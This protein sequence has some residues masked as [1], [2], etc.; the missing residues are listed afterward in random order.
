MR[1][2]VI[3]PI[4]RGEN[5]LTDCLNSLKEGSFR[6]MEVLVVGDHVEEFNPEEVVKPYAAELS[7]RVLELTDQTGTAAARNLGLA[8]A[9][10]DY[11]FFL[12][13]D[14][15]IY[16]DLLGRLSA[17]A[18]EK[19]ADIAY[20][21]IVPTWVRHDVFQSTFDPE[22]IKAPRRDSETGGL[23]RHEL[24]NVA[25]QQ[26]PK[27]VT[28]SEDLLEARNRLYLNTNGIK[29]ISV[30]GILMRRAV[31]EKT[32]IRFNSEFTY[33]SDLSFVSELLSAI[34]S[35]VYCD[36]AIYVKR[37][38]NDPDFFPSLSQIKDENKFDEYIL[39]YYYTC[40][41]IAKTGD[42]RAC[43]D[44]K[45]INYYCGFFMTRLH[46]SGNEDWKGLRFM[47]MCEI[48]KQLHPAAVESL[49]WYQ[50]HAVA[51]LKAGNANASLKLVNCRL[52]L[53]KLR[54][55]CTKHV[56]ISKFC[57]RHFFLKKPLLENTVLCETFFGKSYSDSPK[58]IYEYLQKNYPG[59]YRFVW[60]VNQKT[61]IP[62]PHKT[63][64]RFSVRYAYY[65]ARAK[66]FV[67]NV[68]QP[69]WAQKREGNIF[70]ETWHGTPL[71]KLVFD[72]EEVMAAS[73]L[74]K[75]QFFKQVQHWDYLVAANQFSSETFRSC[76]KFEKK[77]LEYGYPRNDILHSPDREE[78]AEK[79]RAKLGIPKDKK[80]ILYAPTWRDDEY[81][82]RGEYKFALKF[83]LPKMREALGP[84]YVLLLRTH[85]FIADSIDTTGVEDFAINVSHYDDISELY[86]ISDILITDYSSVFFDYAGLRR[87]ILF[88]PY[89][90][91]KYRD[92]LRGFYIS[93][94]DDVPGPLL[95]TQDEIVQGIRNIDQIEAQY[96]EKY[97]IFYERFCK[98]E[99][100]HAAEN[101]AKE[102][103]GLK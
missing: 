65:L 58:Y 72:Q 96:Q 40:G 10:G 101:C 102:V 103:F 87:P 11:V 22:N 75:H 34:R 35:A 49:R 84:D 52:A 38:H 1:V 90:L 54:D 92:V 85:Y 97:D 48:A 27:G 8:E 4:N 3:I 39:A 63:V 2:S 56:E 32:K 26:P 28:L 61:K 73:P 79:I 16:G 29:S 7:A 88:Y 91:E 78:I 14:D 6:D 45:L 89:D 80:T 24:D 50:S 68:R 99:D 18:E 69:T 94:E 62:Y 59:R 82:G 51:L 83:D 19:N 93:I 60:V 44:R 21:K 33:Y 86:L 53:K 9:K 47:Q 70:L 55:F 23:T 43:L 42:I 17:A 30:L 20:G 95:F 15:Y 76:F 31:V 100:G 98:W 74:Y 36:D 71:K 37:K 64:K 13:A 77:M 81:Y 25:V 12:D 5:Y 57:Y 41:K 46:R 67:F 66:Y